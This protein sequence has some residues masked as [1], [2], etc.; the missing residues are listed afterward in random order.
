MKKIAVLFY[1]IPII[2]F[3]FFGCKKKTTSSIILDL[4]IKHHMG[5]VQSLPSNVYVEIWKNYKN[6]KHELLWTGSIDENGKLYTEVTDHD[7]DK[8][9][10][11]YRYSS[12]SG[13]SGGGPLHMQ[14]RK[15]VSE[16]QNSIL[17]KNT[18]NTVEITYANFT[19]HNMA[20]VNSNCSGPND[21]FRYRRRYK[22]IEPK[23]WSNWSENN[24]GCGLKKDVDF[25]YDDYVIYQYEVERNGILNTY[26]DTLT[27]SWTSAIPDTIYY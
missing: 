18:V 25:T 24:Y 16:P 27:T 21:R 12:I 10:Y 17:E 9:E 15:V 14:P 19:V 6:G 3:L 8:V 4:H 23:N 1:T 22:N 5:F 2:I 20:F 13:E 7:Y 26:T 11:Y